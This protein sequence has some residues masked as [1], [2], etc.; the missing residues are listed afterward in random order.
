LQSDM[1][2]GELVDTR[3]A[4]QRRRDTTRQGEKQLTMFS[5]Q[6]APIGVLRTK[7]IVDISVVPTPALILEQEDPRTEEEKEIARRRAMED[8]TLKMFDD[9]S[10]YRVSSEESELG[11]EVAL[12]E[13][14]SML[15]NDPREP[16]YSPKEEAYREIINAAHETENTTWVNSLYTDK[17]HQWLPNAVHAGKEIGLSDT[18]IS[19]ALQIGQT[20]AKQG[21]KDL[22]NVSAS[23]SE[24]E[25]Q[26]AGEPDLHQSKTQREGLRARLRRESFAQY[27][28]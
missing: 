23:V 24:E 17:F 12:E 25:A 9:P 11:E 4:Y 2:S 21:R 27:A 6:E 18:E 13:D 22:E 3:N 26:K 15:G 7:P 8:D 20:L 14:E 5:N 1:F 10:L 16:S 19:S 28:R